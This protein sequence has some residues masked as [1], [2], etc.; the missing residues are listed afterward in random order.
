MIETETRRS[1]ATVL[2]L[3]NLGK[4]DTGENLKAI[5][6]RPVFILSTGRTG[7]QF[8]ARHF[9]RDPRTHAVHEPSPSLGLRF[10]TVAYLEGQVQPSAMT[11]T[12]RRYRTGFFRDIAEPVYIESNNFL[13][14]FAEA[15]IEEFDE[16]LL[17]HVVR[18]PRTY[19]RS[20]INNGANTGVK[21]LANRLVPFAHLPL[22]SESE[23]PAIQRSALYWSLL[24]KYLH[25]VGK[26]YSSYHCVR[27][28][29]LFVSD[30]SRFRWLTELV[31]AGQYER[32]VDESR[33]VNES[34]RDLIPPWSQWSEG[35][36]RVVT[37]T[38][39]EV[40]ALFD[41]DV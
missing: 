40:M 21:G 4:R 8:L 25:E 32:P 37:E 39:A 36:K 41:Y 33:R 30:M 17:I 18:D 23:H 26:D 34:P 12:L 38:C 22:D 19:V 5:L 7:T 14:G 24:N 6:P 13:A 31:G 35:Q 11:R 27:Y 28:E 29:D 10:W 2:R 20:A 3:F 1:A 9:D 16:P 15:L